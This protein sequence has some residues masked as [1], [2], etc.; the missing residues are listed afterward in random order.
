VTAMVGLLT[1]L[2][3]TALYRRLAREGRILAETC[4]NNTDA[5]INFVTRL[6]REF[7]IAGYSELMRKLYEP[8]HY[9]RRI[10]AFLRTYQPRGPSVRLSGSEVKAFL[11]SLWV[12]GVRHAG[13]RAYWG[14]FWSTLLVNPRKFHTAMELSILGYHFRRI[15]NCL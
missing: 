13:R 10:R 6:D 3:E 2:P 5:A 14:L 12:L 4:G 7:L 11:K 15:A 1:A 9:Y 8:K